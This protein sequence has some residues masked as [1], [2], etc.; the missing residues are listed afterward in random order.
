[1]KLLPMSQGYEFQSSPVPKDGRYLYPR[2]ER[3][4]HVCFNPRPS[5]RTGATNIQHLSGDHIDCF[6]PRPSRRTGATYRCQWASLAS[7][8]CFNPR[9]SRRTGATWTLS[10]PHR[11]PFRFNP[12]PSRRTG[13]TSKIGVTTPGTGAFQSSPVPKDGRYKGACDGRG[14]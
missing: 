12:R 1:M 2:R 9:P 4:D 6:N 11:Y 5:R 14:R 3:I 13:A 7:G 8:R 10:R